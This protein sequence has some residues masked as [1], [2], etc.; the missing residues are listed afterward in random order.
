MSSNLGLLLNLLIYD[1][2][3]LNN[4][5][6]SAQHEEL[7]IYCIMIVSSVTLFCYYNR[8]KYL[9]C[10]CKTFLF[11]V[12]L[13]PFLFVFV[14]ILNNRCDFDKAYLAFFNFTETLHFLPST[15]DRN[16][17]IFKL[18]SYFAVVLF[19]LATKISCNFDKQKVIFVYN[20]LFLLIISLTCIIGDYFKLW[21]SQYSLAYAY[22]NNY[23]LLLIATSAVFLI[24]IDIRRYFFLLC[25]VIILNLTVLSVI[26]KSRLGL[27]AITLVI[28]FLSINAINFF[29]NIKKYGRKI[30][31]IFTFLTILVFSNMLD[32]RIFKLNPWHSI[33]IEVP[34][35]SILN[36]KSIIYSESLND[37]RLFTLTDKKNIT[38]RTFEFTLQSPKKD[39]IEYYYLKNGTYIQDS[40]KLNTNVCST[41]LLKTEIQLRNNSIELELKSN[42]RLIASKIIDN[43]YPVKNG[44]HLLFPE[45]P[46]Y[47][48]DKQP[49]FENVSYEVVTNNRLEPSYVFSYNNLKFH[50]IFRQAGSSRYELYKT[51]LIIISENLWFGTGLGTWRFLYLLQRPTGH[52]WDYW[53]HCDYLQFLS[54]LGLIGI[55]PMIYM[56]CLCFKT[57]YNC[58]VLKLR[59]VFMILATTLICVFL[60]I[61]FDF[62]LQVFS[63]ALSITVIFSCIPHPLRQ[64]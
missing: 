48:S 2:V 24:N 22:K 18:K 52:K 45:V 63:T 28:V 55:L 21:P 26:L 17:T 19:F 1:F 35:N 61:L 46:I 60:F 31:Y 11:W 38:Y 15:C 49:I 44:L 12:I 34:D 6:T 64:P 50:D 42:N 16:T 8:T 7:A 51:T 59:K 43:L 58:Y 10:N 54:E 25:A 23:I 47:H 62:P 4:G 9:F 32:L 13:F 29:F 5:S 33:P 56:F 57:L 39:F 27:L 14:S 37:V 41:N 20:S 40:I 36:L 53:A 3:I 30:T